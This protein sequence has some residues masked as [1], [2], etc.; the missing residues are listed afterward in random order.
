ME[1]SSPFV[2]Y[3]TPFFM[4]AL[5]LFGGYILIR[6]CLV[7]NKFLFRRKILRSAVISKSAAAACLATY[8]GTGS[9]LA[10]DWYPYRSPFGTLYE[11]IPC[12]LVLNGKIL[13]IE[14]C[15]AA[16][17]IENTHEKT[18]HAVYTYRNG[19][20]KEIDFDNPVDK[21]KDHA[22]IL[23]S[24]FEKLELPF[25][26][27]IEYLAVFTHSRTTFTYKHGKEISLFREALN[28]FH[29]ESKQKTLSKQEMR[30]LI[31]TLQKY[32]ISR[33]QAIAK[34]N[35]VRRKGR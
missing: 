34:N 23:S 6:L 4:C 7:I 12:I 30:A 13:V 16:G 3:L 11:Q 28:R 8:F 9:V 27:E 22:D 35:S 21:A 10:D 5:F 32:S 2:E 25:E 19:K 31:Q 29:K 17:V 1:R 33:R 15:S 24:L 18:W 26:T 14:F 20:K